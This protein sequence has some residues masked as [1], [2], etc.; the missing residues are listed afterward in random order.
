MFVVKNG[1]NGMGV[2]FFPR[3][4]EDRY[5]RDTSVF[6]GDLFLVLKGRYPIAL[7]EYRELYCFRLNKNVWV[8]VVFAD[9]YEEIA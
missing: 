1:L 9:H 5:S 2:D 3:T 7:T 8:N 4:T 6:S